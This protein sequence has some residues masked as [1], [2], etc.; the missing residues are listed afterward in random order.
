MEFG[1]FDFSKVFSRA[2][3]EEGNGASGDLNGCQG[4]S[5]RLCQPAM[6]CGASACWG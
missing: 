2:L 4:M 1:I 6:N 3:G 5:S